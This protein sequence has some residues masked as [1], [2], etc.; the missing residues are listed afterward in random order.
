VWILVPDVYSKILLKN[1]VFVK[2]IGKV[3]KAYIIGWSKNIGKK[4]FFEFAFPG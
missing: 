3:K 2:V 1:S 4:C